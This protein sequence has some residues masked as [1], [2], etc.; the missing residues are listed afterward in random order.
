MGKWPLCFL[1]L[2]C[3][4]PVSSDGQLKLCVITQ[5]HRRKYQQVAL[6]SLL[7]AEHINTNDDTFVHK[8]HQVS[9]N[10]QIK[11][12]SEGTTEQTIQQV[13]DCINDGSA[14]VI[15]PA[16]SSSVEAVS[17]YATPNQVPAISSSA[18]STL[19]SGIPYFTRTVPSDAAV[20]TAVAALVRQARWARIAFLFS[21]D[22]FGLG[23]LKFCKREL[24]PLI[25]SGE[26]QWLE[27]N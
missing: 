14:A 21:Y 3:P 15:G 7:A 26:L 24:S 20:C 4:F 18:T 5:L 8:R 1:L 6:A 9:V 25:K 2:C 17:L 11:M 13:A 19:L 27:G 16:Y 23:L 22:T 10:V 12:V